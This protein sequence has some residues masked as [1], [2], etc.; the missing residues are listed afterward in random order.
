MLDPSTVAEDAATG[1]ASNFTAAG[2]R[3]GEFA[4]RANPVDGYCDVIVH[5][6]PADFGPTV[7]AWNEGTN[8]S[9]LNQ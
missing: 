1:G 7:N 3:F 4:S 2:D 6:A 8:F 5:G 9:H